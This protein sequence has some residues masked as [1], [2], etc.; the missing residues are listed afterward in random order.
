MAQEQEEEMTLGLCAEA[1]HSSFPKHTENMTP[2]A[3]SRNFPKD[4]PGVLM[5]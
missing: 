4:S 1:G 5:E 3:I 2:A